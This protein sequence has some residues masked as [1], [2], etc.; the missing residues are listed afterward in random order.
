MLYENKHTHEVW[1]ISH[2]ETVPN[3]PKP[4]RVWVFENLQRWCEE[5][6]FRDW[7]LVETSNNT[8]TAQEDKS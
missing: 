5:E 7:K 2:V 4:I 6:F 3:Y 8:L 1:K